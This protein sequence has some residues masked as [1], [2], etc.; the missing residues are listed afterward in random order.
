MCIRHVE[1]ITLVELKS[2][3]SLNCSAFSSMTNLQCDVQMRA[4][5]RGKFQGSLPFVHW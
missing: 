3:S 5:N 2:K 4:A 1:T